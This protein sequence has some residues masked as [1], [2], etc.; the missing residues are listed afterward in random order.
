MNKRIEWVDIC[1][2]LAISLMIAGHIGVPKMLD[3][4]IHAF[5]MPVF[6]IL[7]GLVYDESKNMLFGEYIKK[8][9]KQLLTPYFVYGA[10]SYIWYVIF[11]KFSHSEYYGIAVFL[12][13]MFFM[14]AANPAFAGVGIVQWFFTAMLFCSIFSWIMLRISLILK[15]PLAFKTGCI[16]LL[17]IVSTVLKYLH[18]PNILG[19]VSGII[20]SA[21]YILGNILRGCVSRLESVAILEIFFGGAY[22]S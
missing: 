18:V 10:I 2:F 9:A 21:F 8:R 16:I 11:S 20:G 22:L 19:M 1:K 5:H 7:A 3:V 12:K 6:F 15:W 17:L 4:I 13:E 14:D